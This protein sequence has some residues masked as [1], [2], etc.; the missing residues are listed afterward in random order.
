[1]QVNQYVLFTLRGGE[2]PSGYARSKNKEK[3]FCERMV[4]KMKTRYVA[5]I[6]LM[7]ALWIAAAA[8][9]VAESDDYYFPVSPASLDENSISQEEAITAAK[10]VML[11]REGA[12]FEEHE[13]STIKAGFVQLESGE[14]A[15]NVMLDSAYG[16]DALVLLSPAGE[17]IHYQATDDKSPEIT[18]ILQKKWQEEKGNIQ[19][20]S[21]EDKALWYWLYGSADAYIVPTE[22]D[23][24]Q[25]RAV[26]IALEAVPEELSDPSYTISFGTYHKDASLRVWSITIYENGKEAYVVYV[27]AE[28][29]T[30]IEQFPVSS[31]G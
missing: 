17:V 1:M 29:G 12:P 9:A 22:N 18:T 15:W 31:L 25:E 21:I 4:M 27:T 20:W 16:T 13:Q 3:K 6:V 14:N 2:K 11:Q 10:D 26:K 28:D 5:G 8:F 23:I 30:V 7:L 19:S 24:S